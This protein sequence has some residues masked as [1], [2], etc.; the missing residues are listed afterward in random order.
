MTVRR[1][2]G[3]AALAVVGCAAPTGA[4]E[5]PAPALPGEGWV[6]D[7]YGIEV[8]DAEGVPFEHPFMGGFDV[9]RPQLVDLDGDG[10]LDLFLQERTG[11]LIHYENVGTGFE[12]AF[13]WRSDTYRDLDIGEWS[14]F[15]DMDGDGDLDLV[16]EERFSYIRWFRNEG[17]PTAPSFSLAADTLRDVEG[18]P[19]F[20]DR[21]NIPALVDIDCDGLTDLFLGRV[22]GTVTRY[23]EV[24]AGTGRFAFV[25]DRFQ[26]IEIV[27][28]AGIPGGP[29]GGTALHGANSMAFADADED[30]DLDLFWG[31]F[32]E[33]GLLWIENGGSCERPDL[34]TRPVPVPAVETIATSGYNAPFLADL[35]GDGG[36]ELFLGVLGGAFN[37]NRTVSSN[38]YHYD[39]LPDGRV[40]LVTERLLYGIDLGSES[41]LSLGDLDGDGDLDMVAAPKLDPAD[42]GISRLYRFENV[43]TATEPRFALADTTSLVDNFH[44]APELADLDGDG[45]LDLLLGTWNDGVHYYRDAGT[46]GALVWEPVGE[47][48]LVE[49][50]RGSHSVPAAGDLDGDGDLDLV[51]GE[52]VGELNLYRNVGSA[53]EP[54]FEWVTD[55]LGGIDP[56]RRSAPTLTDLDGDGRVDLIVGSEEGGA[57]VFRNEGWTGEHPTFVPMELDLPLP[58]MGRAALADLDGDGRAELLS[59]TTT[60]GVVFFRPG[61]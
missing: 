43:G 11:A 51:V 42:L 53:T 6:R 54:R 27:G 35:D 5:G 46:G 28:Q 22:D 34:T 20:S 21:Q 3:W 23:E 45:R 50:S 52:A 29:G 41:S 2:A 44:F 15:H 48:P 9:P 39:R 18:E 61:G 57:L 60:G 24:E 55:T 33:P 19:I 4:P 32:F 1:L 26:Q 30:G 56:G 36:L 49:L 17:T 8:L 12:P 38:L 59:G 47:G 40:E 10:D 37:A 7:V 31:D 58:T 16:A 14:R 13:R 25:T